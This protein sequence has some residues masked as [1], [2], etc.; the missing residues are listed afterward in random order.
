M[1]QFLASLNQGYRIGRS[2]TFL[3]L[4][5]IFIILL[6]ISCLSL[7]VSVGGYMYSIENA[8][9]LELDSRSWLIGIIISGVSILLLL[10]FITIL[11]FRPF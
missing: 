4:I 8:E 2:W 11:S 5:R 3:S 6:W 9:I 1:T 7:G 10:I